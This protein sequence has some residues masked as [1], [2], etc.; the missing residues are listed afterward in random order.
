[1]TKRMV[2]TCLGVLIL[3]CFSSVC[4]A[5][6]KFKITADDYTLTVSQ[7]AT[8]DIWANITDTVAANNGLNVW[9]LDMIVDIGGIVQ[10]SADPSLIAPTPVDPSSGWLSYN[11]DKTGNVNGLGV[12]TPGPTDSV[13]GI[14]GFDLLAQVT[15]EAIGTVGQ[16][17]T[18]G[19]TNT[20]LGGSFI[21]AL[22][23]D[24]SGP[25]YVY[26]TNIQFLQG[27]NVFTIV[28]EPATFI[29]LAAGATMAMRRKK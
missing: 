24:S 28:P 18:Y 23:D 4:S 20:G 6:L 25:S 15:I 10:V 29:L 3:L 11:T 5:D 13:T 8:I 26:P 19:L 21:G 2:Y 9:Q 16:Q 14:G 12:F 7:T 1:M 22:R 17:V 27:N